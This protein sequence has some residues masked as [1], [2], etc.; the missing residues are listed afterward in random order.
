MDKKKVLG[1]LT[2][3][4]GRTSHTAIMA[5]TLEVAAVV[6]LTDATQ[7]IKDGDFVVFNGDTGEVIVNP[8]EETIAKYSQMKK[9]FEDYKNH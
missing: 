1:F 3:I 2:D 7:K 4:G 5:R 6:G 8:D 9:E